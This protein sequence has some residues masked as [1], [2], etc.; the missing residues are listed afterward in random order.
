[1]HVTP[2]SDQLKLVKLA[3]LFQ[4]KQTFIPLVNFFEKICIEQRLRLQQ[5]IT[6]AMISCRTP[7]LSKVSNRAVN[8]NPLS[9]QSSS[10]AAAAADCYCFETCSLKKTSSM[11]CS[12]S[13]F[14][15]DDT[16]DIE[17]REDCKKQQKNPLEE[18]SL[19]QFL[20]SK[21]LLLFCFL[22]N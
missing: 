8:V 22:S 1:M 14:V 19:L 3:L 17:S 12:A 11:W 4:T 13:I 7:C 5:F 21:S 18:L 20:R 6:K 10:R 9:M 2:W 15:Q 16:D